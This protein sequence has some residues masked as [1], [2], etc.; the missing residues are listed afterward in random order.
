MEIRLLKFFVS[1][2]EQKNLTRAAEHCF[3]S[4]PNISN[5]IKQL[6][7][8]IGQRLFERNKKGVE[9]TNEAHQLYPTAKRL[10]NEVNGISTMFRTRS[11]QHSIKIGVTESLPQEHKQQF[12]RKVSN[13]LGS[14]QWEVNEISRENEINLLVREWKFEE[15]LFLPLWKEDYVLCIPNGNPLLQKETIE[16]SDLENETFIHC[17]PCEAHQQCLSILN[18]ES[19]QMKT[20]AN[21]ST[22]TETLSFLMAGLGVTFL[23]ESFVNGWYGFEIRPYNGPRYFREVGLSY[24][25]KSLQNPAIVSLIEHY[26]KNKLITNSRG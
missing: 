1:V 18:H 14:L 22:K 2:Y 5:G 23:P 19:N 13:R 24:P 9:L 4:Q 6:E 15:D 16:L 26:S 3:V 17:P 25:R 20:I 8:E 7:E 10:L 12:Y 21:C 11:F